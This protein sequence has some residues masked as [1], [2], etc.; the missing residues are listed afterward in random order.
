MGDS[1][2]DWP[3]FVACLLSLILAPVENGGRSRPPRAQFSLLAKH[4]SHLIGSSETTESGFD[5]L[6]QRATQK[7]TPDEGAADALPAIIQILHLLL[8]EYMLLELHRQECH[9]LAE[10]LGA[11]TLAPGWGLF[12]AYYATYFGFSPSDTMKASFLPLAISP[13]VAEPF[14]I[15]RH[16]S[17]KASL[18]LTAFIEEIGSLCSDSAARTVAA[19]FPALLT[20]AGKQALP[21]HL[22]IPPLQVYLR[23]SEAK[24]ERS[25]PVKDI[26][27]DS[28]SFHLDASGKV[29]EGKYC[30]AKGQN[31]LWESSQEG[32]FTDHR[33]AEI[34]DLLSPAASETYVH[35]GPYD[36]R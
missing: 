12:N 15:F 35:S 34:R 13:P 19:I 25:S 28:I 17:S 30:P 26:A 23:D 18:C 14:C 31:H 21:T 4:Y 7:A 16:L 5:G 8:Q 6:I 22:F 2:A 29:V 9:Q 32:L 36:T 3:R 24:Q 20:L 10:L 33:L 1:S 11:L 27:S